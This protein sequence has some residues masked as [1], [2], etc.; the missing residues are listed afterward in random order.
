MPFTK[1]FI[2]MS[3]S[4]AVLTSG[5]MLAGQAEAKPDK[6]VGQ[7]CSQQYDCVY[8]SLTPEK[9]AQY[10]AIMKDFADRTAPLRDQLSAKYIELRTLGNSPAPDPK[11]VGKASEELVALR[12][13]FSGERQ[14]MVERIA[15]EVG[16]N[17]FQ[18]REKRMPHDAMNGMGTPGQGCNQ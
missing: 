12:N 1:T 17:V 14:A 9:Q 16:V 5:I 6:K 13:T 3:L 4:V 18:G 10:D 7:N 11:A 8:Q 15:K 2:A